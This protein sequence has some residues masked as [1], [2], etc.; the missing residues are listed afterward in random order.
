MS[1]RINISDEAEHS[2]KEP[3]KYSG[4]ACVSLVGPW[5]VLKIQYLP[6]ENLG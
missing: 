4:L 5:S 6:Y 2:R 1:A 3:K